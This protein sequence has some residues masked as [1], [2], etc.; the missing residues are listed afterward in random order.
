MK[1]VI[2]LDKSIVEGRLEYHSFSN[3]VFVQKLW[4]LK[5]EK[6]TFSHFQQKIQKK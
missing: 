2:W 1:I 6:Y 3:Y 5:V 4:N